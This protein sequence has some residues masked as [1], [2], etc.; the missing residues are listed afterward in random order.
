MWCVLFQK[1]KNIIHGRLSDKRWRRV[2]S[3]CFLSN[4]LKAVSLLEALVASV[5]LLI[6]FTV[7][8]A[9]VARLTTTSAN[10]M[11]YAE[12]HYRI[13]S[14]VHDVQKGEWKNGGFEQTYDWGSIKVHIEPYLFCP[15]LRQLT[16][17]A[18]IPGVIGQKMQYRCLIDF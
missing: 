6:V 15:L 7:S 18:I 1:R 12:V 5:I 8:L 11:I 17:T 16:V 10:D 13:L 2:L 4:R 9:T 14:A 3:E